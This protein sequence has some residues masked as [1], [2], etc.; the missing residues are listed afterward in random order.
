MTLAQVARFP[1]GLIATL[2]KPLGSRKNPPTILHQLLFRRRI[3][4]INAF[5][6]ET[7]TRLGSAS[8]S[9]W[10]SIIM[11]D[12]LSSKERQKPCQGDGKMN[13]FEIQKSKVKLPLDRPNLLLGIQTSQYS[14]NLVAA[15]SLTHNIGEADDFYAAT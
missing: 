1:V 13:A 5:P 12:L 2:H 9:L 15:K 7:S 11:T 4:D 6:E 8:N 10:W 3:L 14:S